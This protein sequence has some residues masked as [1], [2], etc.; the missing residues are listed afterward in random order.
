MKRRIDPNRTL[1]GKPVG[2]FDPKRDTLL[3]PKRDEK[4]EKKEPEGEPKKKKR[5]TSAKHGKWSE[6]FCKA[7]MD[8][9]YKKVKRFIDNGTDVNAID[10]GGR[11]ALMWAAF[12][13]EKEVAELLIQ[14]GANVHLRDNEGKT[15]RNWAN[16]VKTDEHTEVAE[17]L[18]VAERQ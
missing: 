8:G 10:T 14:N 5:K 2:K 3:E 12:C 4:A 17:I 1:C 15:A 13:G 18:R 16:E 6:W 11:T 7:V 9:N